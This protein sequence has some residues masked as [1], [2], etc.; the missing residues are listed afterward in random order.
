MAAQSQQAALSY[1]SQLFGGPS[2]QDIKYI[3]NNYTIL[4]DYINEI[5]NAAYGPSSSQA[6]AYQGI[7]NFTVMYNAS[8]PINFAAAVEDLL[9]TAVNNVTKNLLFVENN[10]QSMAPQ[11]LGDQVRIV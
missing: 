3:G 5:A 6:V 1:T 8:Y 7:T 11:V 2:A 4:F 10:V 9:N